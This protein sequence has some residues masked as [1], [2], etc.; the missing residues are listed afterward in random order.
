MVDVATAAPVCGLRVVGRRRRGRHAAAGA[1]VVAEKYP[2]LRL[3]PSTLPRSF[4]MA[5]LLEKSLCP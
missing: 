1:R 5:G 4:S 3:P 2:G